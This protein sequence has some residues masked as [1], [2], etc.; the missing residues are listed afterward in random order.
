MKRIVVG[1]MLVA[2]V[3]LAGSTLLMAQEGGQRPAF[4]PN[5]NS[6]GEIKS[7]DATAMT[8][9][10]ERVNRRTGETTQDVIY[11]NDKTTYEKDGNSAKFSDF[12]VG[13]RVRATGERKDGKFWADKVSTMAPRP[14]AQ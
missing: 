7:I 8:F 11:C 12:K 13:D 9:S 5:K 3:L 10:V 1:A 4:D 2:L 14:P 6:G